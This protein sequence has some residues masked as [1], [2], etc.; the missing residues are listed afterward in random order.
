MTKDY[1]EKYQKPAATVYELLKM[2]KDESQTK[3]QGFLSRQRL[4]N[5]TW[6]ATK[7]SF[8]RCKNSKVSFLNRF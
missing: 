5:F 7:I 6:I 1:C 2:Q 8:L 4:L 3:K